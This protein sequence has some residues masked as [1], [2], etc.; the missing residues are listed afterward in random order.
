MSRRSDG[1]TERRSDA[2][3]AC[4]RTLIACCV[5]ALGLA[6]S[7]LAQGTSSGIVITGGPDGSGQNYEWTVT[8]NGSQTITEIA[9]PHYNAD[10]F[11]VPAPWEQECTNLQR[12]GATK[13]DGVCRAFV[14]EPERGIL[15]GRNAK[16]GMRL[17]RV[18]ADR[19]TGEV[20]VTLADATKLTIAGVTLPVGQSMVQRYAMTGGMTTVLILFI[21]MQARRRRKQRAAA[22]ASAENNSGA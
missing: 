4:L 17:A 16:F 1:A 11:I 5:V 21:A 7:A 6:S 9:F 18:S 10:T 19:G 20:T 8:N 3:W 2:G 13:S 15:P 22:A 14:K 12:L